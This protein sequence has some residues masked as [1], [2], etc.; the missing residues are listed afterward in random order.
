MYYNVFLIIFL[1]NAMENSCLLKLQVLQ[2]TWDLRALF[3]VYLKS[4]YNLFLELIAL[5]WNVIINFCS[6][7]Y[8]FN[9]AKIR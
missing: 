6:L 2:R 5:E 4:T 9:I 1:V 8:C 3:F 7:K